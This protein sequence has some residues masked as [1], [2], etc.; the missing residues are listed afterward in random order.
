[1]IDGREAALYRGQVRKAM[2]LYINILDKGQLVLYTRSDT[3]RHAGIVF[4]GA[5]VS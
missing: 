4:R 1:M 2:I 5:S 3:S